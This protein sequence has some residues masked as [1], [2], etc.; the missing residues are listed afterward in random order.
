M[1]DVFHL[2]GTTIDGKYRVDDLI[3][4][5]G[6]GVVY[7]GWRPA[8]EDSIAIKCLKIPHDFSE[9]AR[10]R[11]LERFREEG[12]LLARLSKA[13]LSIVQVYDF[14]VAQSHA[15]L[16]LPYLVLEW[17]DGRDLGRVVRDLGR[18]LREAEAVALLRPAMEAIA[19]AH[20][21]RIA[22]RDLK[23]ANVFLVRSPSGPRL[24]V[25]DFG[26]AKAMHEGESVAQQSTRTAST[27][28]AF[29]PTYGAPEQFHYAPTGPWTDVHALALILV[30][31]VTGRSPLEGRHQF[32]LF[33]SATSQQR[34]TPRSRGG[35]VS[36][37]FERACAR[38]LSLDPKDRQAD[39]GELL[40]ELE[41]ACGDQLEQASVILDALSSCGDDAGHPSEIARAATVTAQPPSVPASASTP[42]VAGPGS[43][44][45]AAVATAHSVGLAAT[46]H[47][48]GLAATHPSP[49]L[50]VTNDTRPA[51]TS[52]A[53]ADSPGL[54]APPVEPPHRK[55]TSI[56]LIIAI[57]LPVALA[58]GLVL[59]AVAG[60]ALF[61]VRAPPPPPIAI[62]SGPVPVA[63]PSALVPAPARLVPIVG[64]TFSLGSSD[65]PDNER[66]VTRTTVASFQLDDVE[67]TVSAYRACVQAGRCTEPGSG[68][69]CNW[70]VEGRDQHPINCV[71]W[72]QAAAY[73][74][75]VKRRL[76]TEQ[77]WE[78][79][80]RGADGR[81][82]P[83]GKDAPDTRA[84]HGG[85]SEGGT[86]AVGSFR[87]GASAFGVLDMV[88]NV[89]EW[90]AS[91]ACPHGDLACDSPNK[92]L[93]GGSF[94]D[95]D[96][97]FL[98]ATSRL[99]R[100]PTTRVNN[101]GM[102]CAK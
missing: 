74:A 85:N 62:S 86:C 72:S 14:G 29:S 8:F 39:A 87:A 98:R 84:C 94:L 4:E 68:A 33:T 81:K 11:F 50:R 35:D 76:P 23:P 34:P 90:T 30:E 2:L 3:G 65:G 47:S 59:I 83:W 77:E 44:D 9:E 18:P 41:V 32:E 45:T 51:D 21:M 48:V 40:R 60:A 26:I 13:H 15:G 78:Y 10:I 102:R 79:A 53:A 97:Q 49:E 36:E 17:L 101:F 12:K 28:N 99:S 73:C 82:Y 67:T 38:A 46:A 71:D 19:V 92:V 69:A 75:W 27:F 52:P 6:F 1:E 100:P 89:W 54:M 25:L 80:A 7:R 93:R 37:A 43:P 64:G 24:K 88:G 42:T 5:G 58:L 61:T 96:R 22:H 55:K 31:L 66:P 20:G 91:A 70:G 95:K 56:G 16:P 63:V 57:A